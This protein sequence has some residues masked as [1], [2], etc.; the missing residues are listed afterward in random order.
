M[1]LNQGWHYNF[2]NPNVSESTLRFSQA[3]SE[4]AFL[5]Q[6]PTRNQNSSLPNTSSEGQDQSSVGLKV[7]SP[8]NKRDFVMFKLREISLSDFSSPEHLKEV[9]LNQVGPDVVS[10]KLDFPVGFINKCEKFWINNELDIKDAREV[11][12]SGKLT[13]WCVGKEKRG[14]KRSQE[15]NDENSDEEECGN[16]KK[17]TTSSEERSSRVKDLKARIREKHGPSY[18][19]TQYSLWAEMIVAGSH[20]SMEE[21]PHVPMFGSNRP[22]GRS[23]RFEE[24][25]C[26]AAGKIANALSPAPSSNSNS[27]SKSTELRGRYIQQLK[28]IVN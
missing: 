19:G 14:K 13:L 3:P 11:F 15:R 8:T 20:E 12:S 28:D 24:T 23:N 27:P 2:Y 10:T 25:L 1:E 6:F 4:R 18:S 7:F 21:P 16:S 5:N 9:I 17:K 22:R 26:D